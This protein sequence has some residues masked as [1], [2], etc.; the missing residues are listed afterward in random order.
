[1]NF[2]IL[3]DESEE[4]HPVSESERVY[5]SFE[6]S[7]IV[8]GAGDLESSLRNVELGERANDHVDPLVLLQPPEVDEQRTLRSLNGIGGKAG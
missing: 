8:A 2:F 3:G 6:L 1:V 7:A 5:Q 4:L